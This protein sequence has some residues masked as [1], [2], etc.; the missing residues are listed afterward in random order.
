MSNQKKKK[1]NDCLDVAF[2]NNNIDTLIECMYE[3]GITTPNRIKYFLSQ[4][5]HESGGFRHFKENMNYSASGL[6]SVFPKRF[7][8]KTSKEYARKPEKIANYVYGGRMGN[9][10][11]GDGY[12]YIGRGLIQLTGKNNYKAIKN[13]IGVDIV[14]NPELVS[15]DPKITIRSACGF[16]KMNKLNSFADKNDMKKISTIIQGNLS[17]LEPRI[18]ALKKIEKSAKFQQIC[19]K[20]ENFIENNNNFSSPSSL[21]SLDNKDFYVKLLK[22]QIKYAKG[23][24]SNGDNS[25]SNNNNNPSHYFS[26]DN[27]DIYVKALKEQLKYIKE[28]EKVRESD[29]DDSDS[30]STNLHSDLFPPNNKGKKL[31]K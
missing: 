16:L 2:I 28:N 13:I 8:E 19:K 17:A 24:G 4:C 27:R 11:S 18:E 5:F 25:F 15:D 29:S 3:F 10:K 9:N 6:L 23:K 21:F 22:D 14:K 7:N 1:S 31:I 12:K 20:M 26:L 30:D